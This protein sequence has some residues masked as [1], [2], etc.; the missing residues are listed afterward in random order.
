MIASITKIT[1]LNSSGIIPTGGHVLILP[2]KVEEKTSGGIILTAIIRDNEQAAATKGTIVAIG[3]S[4]WKDLD[5]GLPWAKVGDIISYAKYSGVA[6]TGKD[7]T[8]YVLINDN[9]ILAKMLF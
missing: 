5:D 8:D 7:N 2:E 9:D 1:K 3:S 6:M 4:A